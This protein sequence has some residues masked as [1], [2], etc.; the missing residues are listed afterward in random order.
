MLGP[1]DQGIGGPGAGTE[2]RLLLAQHP[3]LEPRLSD[4]CPLTQTQA[5]AQAV[6]TRRSCAE[7]H[8]LPPGRALPGKVEKWKP[9]PYRHYVDMK[10]AAT[11]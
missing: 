1:E 4:S 11:T 8:L 3:F 9:C 10:F 6:P 2:H 5:A 7:R